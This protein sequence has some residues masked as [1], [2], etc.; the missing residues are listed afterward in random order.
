MALFGRRNSEA[1]PLDGVDVVLAD[2]DG[3]VYAGAGALPPG[4]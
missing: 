1:T 3:V 4:E 2:L